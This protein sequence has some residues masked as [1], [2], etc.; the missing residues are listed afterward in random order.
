MKQHIVKI[1][2]SITLMLFS[3]LVLLPVQLF[4]QTHEGNR[5]FLGNII[6]SSIPAD[7]GKYWSQVTPENAGKWGVVGISPDT[8]L[9][10]WSQL[11]RIYDYALQK[12]YPFKFHNLVWGQQQPSWTGGLDLVQQKKM[13]EAWIRLCGE[14]YSKSTYV[15][16]VNEPIQKPAFYKNALGG[17]GR[18]G[19]DWV[20]WS[21][22][23]ARK[24]FPNA[25]LLINDYNILSD[26]VNTREYIEIVN[27][28]KARNLIDGIGC[29]GHGLERVDTNTIKSNLKLLEGAGLPIYISEYDVDEAN[30]AR[31]LEIF[32]EQIPIFWNDPQVEGITLWGYVERQTWR[33][34]TYLVHTDLRERP[35]LEW[36]CQYVSSHPVGERN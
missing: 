17:D 5:K 3:S 35:A 18:T 13:V 36:L 29:Q 6:G 31:Q 30:D 24:A 4:C 10:D 2:R 26:S 1:D 27:L 33:P 12:G 25:K 15:D 14:R 34:N 7:F 19:W 11:D 23:K 16:V 8:N 32:K 20:I 28:L 21:F 22:E 9:W